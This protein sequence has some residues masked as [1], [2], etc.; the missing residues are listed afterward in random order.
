MV[1]HS[2]AARP[3]LNGELA[4][5][6]QNFLAA[7]IPAG[8]HLRV[9]SPLYAPVSVRAIVVP[10]DASLAAPIEARVRRELERFLHPLRGGRAGAGWQFGEPVYLSQIAA[11]I[12]GVA[13]V[14][15]TEEVM[16][17][18]GG[19]LASMALEIP[20]DQ[21]VCAGPHELVLRMG[22]R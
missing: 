12:E 21:L 17:S 3:E 4:R 6:V 20:H 11:S 16:L 13:G 7:R 9:V 19:A 22:S 14:E 2:L 10:A 18:A 1:P 8:M 15:H 5:S